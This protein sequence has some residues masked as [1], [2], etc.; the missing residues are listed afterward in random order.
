MLAFTVRRHKLIATTKRPPKLRS[1]WALVRVRLAGICN[2]DVEILR[3][4]HAFHG[5]PGHEFVGEIADVQGVSPREKSKWLGHRVVGEINVACSA[6]GFRPPCLF[7]RRGLKTHCARRTVLGIV[8]HDGAFAEYLA[9][10]LEN[11]HLVPDSFGDQQAVFVEPLAAACEI[12]D[13]VNVSRFRKAAVLGDG[14]LAQLIAR[15]LLT[16]IPR[17][18]MYGKHGKKLALARRAGIE[19]KRVRGDTSDLKNIKE[20][21]PL[22]VEA[23]GS[24]TGF[25]LAQQMTEPRG[26][27]A[28][29]ST[30]HGAAPVETWPIVVKELNVVGS[31]C[32]PFAK[33]LALL[34][35]GTVDPRPLITRTFPLMDAQTAIRFA[36]QPGVMK[37]L[38]KP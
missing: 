33:A 24:P 5:V 27:L 22:I 20:T 21:F 1:G 11:L 28:L 16:R 35:A 36:Q 9:L 3:G 6:Y 13:Q 14:K 34:R 18:V 29:K 32:G 37:I 7:C 15:V 10:P 25:A 17:V 38:L 19:T 12:L 31:R 26:T 2:T 30:F 4:Y 23:T 8:G